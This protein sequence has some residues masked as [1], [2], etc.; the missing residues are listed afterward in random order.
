LKISF[1]LFNSTTGIL[2]QK[3]SL[4]G[5]LKALREKAGRE[6]IYNTY[7]LA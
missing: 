2:N 3:M 7:V 6:V 5:L 1:K 4:V